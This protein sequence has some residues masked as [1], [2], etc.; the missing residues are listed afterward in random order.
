VEYGNPIIVFPPQKHKCFLLICFR[1]KNQFNT[2]PTADHADYADFIAVPALGGLWSG[3]G[4][5]FSSAAGARGRQLLKSRKS[6]HA[7]RLSSHSGV[8]VSLIII[9]RMFW[10]ASLKWKLGLLVG[11]LAESLV[12]EEYLRKKT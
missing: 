8:L 6:G 7:N 4:S 9:A 12:D 10:F 1:G 3:A 5:R 11:G 2:N